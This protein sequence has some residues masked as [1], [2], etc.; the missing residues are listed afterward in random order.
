MS[1]GP[2]YAVAQNETGF[3]RVLNTHADNAPVQGIFADRKD[4]EKLADKLNTKK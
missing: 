2:Q 1:N 3:W 4:A